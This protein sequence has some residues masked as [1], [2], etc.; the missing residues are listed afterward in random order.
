MDVLFWPMALAGNGD[1][2]KHSMGEDVERQEGVAETSGCLA[3]TDVNGPSRRIK[4]CVRT[5]MKI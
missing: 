3:L 1:G 5:S 4:K 2:E